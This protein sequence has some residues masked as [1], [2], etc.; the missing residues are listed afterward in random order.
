MKRLLILALGLAL[1]LSTVTGADT[2]S[3]FTHDFP[4]PDHAEVIAM[5]SQDPAD[6]PKANLDAKQARKLADFVRAQTWIG[7]AGSCD[8]PQ[9]LL[10]F[11]AGGKLI[12]SDSICFYC[13]CF[14]PLNTDHDPE[15]FDTQTPQA[16]AMAAYL[17]KLFPVGK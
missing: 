15:S 5:R 1:S 7:P 4:Q 10:R 17:A 6:G 13:G 3:S 16:Q 14:A 12:A 8:K 11:Y 9:Y 2:T